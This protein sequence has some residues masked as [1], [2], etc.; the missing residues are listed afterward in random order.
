MP[1]KAQIE[2]VKALIKVNEEKI[3]H[4][5]SDPNALSDEPTMG[6]LVKASA[7]I[8]RHKKAIKSWK[9]ELKRL[10]KRQAEFEKQ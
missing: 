6:G 7:L 1:L 5:E 4:F 10:E 3:K 2:R 8:E 9:K